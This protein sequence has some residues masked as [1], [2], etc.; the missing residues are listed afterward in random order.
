VGEGAGREGKKGG[1][2]AEI[3][4]LGEEKRE[5]KEKRGGLPFSTEKRN[6]IGE[7]DVTP[8]EVGEGEGRSVALSDFHRNA[9]T[10]EKGNERKASCL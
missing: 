7:R 10:G 1:R 8:G 2:G 5:K 4:S 6:L 9:Q 3:P